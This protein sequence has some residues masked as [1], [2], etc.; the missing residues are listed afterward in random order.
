MIERRKKK[1][2]SNLFCIFC[3]KVASR[4][5]WLKENVNQFMSCKKRLKV[6]KV[7]N[8]STYKLS[9]EDRDLCDTP[10]NLVELGA[11]F[12][13]L[14]NESSPGSDGIKPGFLK[15]YWRQPKLPLFKSL[16]N[17]IEIGELSTSQ[18]RRINNLIHIGNNISGYELKN[19]RAS[20]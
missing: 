20:I 11:A 18:R 5:V 6:V 13:L 16:Q 9:E 19:Y 15:M 12:K 7:F 1:F 17:S 2:R 3:P 4:R 14:K 8:G 10:L